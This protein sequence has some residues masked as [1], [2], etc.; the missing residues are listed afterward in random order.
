MKMLLIWFI[1]FGI[2]Q[3]YGK[4]VDCIP[5]SQIKNKVAN[6]SGGEIFNICAG[7]YFDIKLELNGNGKSDKY[8]IIVDGLDKVIFKGKSSLSVTGKYIHIKNF[9]WKNI[10]VDTDSNF[11]A[12]VSI[13][14]YIK[15]KK[16]VL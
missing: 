13:G 5:I 14:N 2:Q 1:I 10:I 15:P 11:F 7:T 4:A 12:I 6:A 9:I 8:P 16:E 3:I